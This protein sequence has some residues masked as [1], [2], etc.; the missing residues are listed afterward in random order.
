MKSAEEV[1]DTALAALGCCCRNGAQHCRHWEYL[2]HLVIAQRAEARREA[3]E[4]ARKALQRIRLEAGR[5]VYGFL[6]RSIG[7]EAGVEECQEAIR[8]LAT[9]E[10]P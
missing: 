7:H 5:H 4:E 10:R 2:R 1:A 6:E 9:K 3:L 8:A